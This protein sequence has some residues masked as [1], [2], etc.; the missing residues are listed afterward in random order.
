MADK[1]FHAS[2][3]FLNESFTL[4][5]I[6]E[7]G[8]IS[9]PTAAIKVDTNVFSTEFREGFGL[10]YLIMAIQWLYSEALIDQSVQ[11]IPENIRTLVSR[12]DLT[13]FGPYFKTA[14]LIFSL[15]DLT[16]GQ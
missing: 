9:L 2:F 13:S 16:F 8:N 5:E 14:V 15:M 7:L 1:N 3:T 10:W 6:E 12:T 4:N 11:S